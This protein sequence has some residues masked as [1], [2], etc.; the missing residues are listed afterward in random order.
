MTRYR[1]LLLF[2]LL[3]A[4]WGSAFMAIKAGLAFFPPVLFA[5][6]RYDV[7]GVLMIGYAAYAADDWRPRTGPQWAMALAGGALMIAG[8]HAFLFVGEQ[9]TTSAAAAVIVAT[10]PILTTGFARGLLVGQRLTVAGVAG[11]LLGL[12]GV[13]ILVQ[14]DPSNLLTAAVRSKLLVLAAAVSF[15]FGS[16]LTRWIDAPLD[17]ETM[18]SWSML[19]GAAL[20]HVVSVGLGESI[21]AVRWTGTGV[22]AL[23]YLSLAASSL[24]FL[25][26]FDLHDRLG[27]VE[28]NL[29]SYVAPVFAALSGFLFLG[30]VIDAVTVTGFLVIVAGF[31]LLKRRELAEELPRLAAVR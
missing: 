16:V 7:A 27:P 2:V 8:Y 5:A 28:I 20:M 24:G 14:P 30:E 17:I 21:S 18:Q 29:V 26:Y 31:A 6:F 13:G 15:A 9:G 25:I 3:A 10:S 4:T 11:L 19:L 22:A 23:L 12:V 1:N